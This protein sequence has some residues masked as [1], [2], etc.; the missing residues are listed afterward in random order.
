[1]LLGITAAVAAIG[2]AVYKYQEE[3]NAANKALEEATERA[4]E[5]KEAFNALN[6]AYNNLKSDIEKYQNAKRALE[7]MTEGTEEWKEQVLQLNESVLELLDSYPKLLKY[8]HQSENGL[9][10]I[11]KEGLDKIL[12]EQQDKLRSAQVYSVQTQI[13]KEQ[14]KVGVDVKELKDEI[15]NAIFKEFTNK[16]VKELS[17]AIAENQETILK[18][19]NEDIKNLI[20][21]TGIDLSNYDDLEFLV[22]DLIQSVKNNNSE[23]IGFDKQ[24]N[25]YTKNVGTYTDTI[26]SILGSDDKTYQNSPNKSVINKQADK[27]YNEEYEKMKKELE[28]SSF[29]DIASLYLGYFGGDNDQI[30][31]NRAHK[32]GVF[33]DKGF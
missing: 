29:E 33:A 24:M 30:V 28:N 22:D 10:S 11:E 14:E 25:S 18:G 12:Q 23:I 1:M 13:S 19:T 27:Y 21:N 26:V 7:F 4:E 8:V 20:K 5:A 3:Q 32:Y 2:F 17:K 16:E 9:M 31:Y 15:D 6:E